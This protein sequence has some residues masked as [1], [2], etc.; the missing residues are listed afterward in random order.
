MRPYQKLALPACR[1][2][3]VKIKMLFKRRRE[4]VE[5]V[6]DPVVKIRIAAVPPD[7]PKK[8]LTKRPFRKQT[9]DISA[10]HPPVF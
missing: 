1:I 2:K 7:M 3:G 10:H 9:V 6:I 4:R 5:R 8:G